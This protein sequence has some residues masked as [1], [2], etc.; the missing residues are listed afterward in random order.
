MFLII[1]LLHVLVLLFGPKLAH[2]VVGFVDYLL[3][4]VKSILIVTINIVLISSQQQQQ[5][6]HIVGF[7][8]KL[9]TIDLKIQLL[10][11]SRRT[12]SKRKFSQIIVPE[13]NNNNSNTAYQSVNNI[14]NLDNLQTEI[15][16]LQHQHIKK[17]IIQNLNTKSIIIS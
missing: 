2:L 5:L 6:K 4:E 12:N 3:L 16:A 7:L 17:I 8:Q 15:Q 14:N 10:E 11:K 9:E 13:L 1:F